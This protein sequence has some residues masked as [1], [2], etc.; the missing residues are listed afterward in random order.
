VEPRRQAHC[1]GIGRRH[2]AGLGRFDAA[3]EPRRSA[4]MGRDALL[5]PCRLDR[6]ALGRVW[7]RSPRRARELPASGRSGARGGRWRRLTRI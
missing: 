2:C 3:P 7:R 5:R 4:A 1:H 6:Q